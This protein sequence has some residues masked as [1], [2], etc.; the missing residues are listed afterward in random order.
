MRNKLEIVL[1]LILI[2]GIGI[3]YLVLPQREFSEMENRYLSECPEFTW[4]EL[5]NGTYTEK[6]EDYTA[7]QIVG[8][9]LLVKLNVAVNRAMGVTEIQQV[10]IGKD[11]YLIQDYQEPGE[12]LQENLDYIRLFAMEHPEI[13]M[14]MLLVP[15]ASEIYPEELPAFAETYSQQAVIEEA[16]KALEPQIEVVDATDSLLTHKEEELYFKTDHHWN[17]LG[18]YYAYVELCKALEVEPTPYSQYQAEVVEQPFYGSL[19]SKAPMFGQVP[20]EMILLKNPEGQY[21]V[22][23]V[24]ENRET[25]SMLDYSYAEKKDKYAIYFG[26]NYPLTVIRSQG[27]EQEKVLII[28][29]SYA[30]SLVPML[31]DQYGEIHMMDLRYYHD[32]V[33]AYIEE[34]GITRVIFIHNV[35][36]IS[37]DNNF[38][39]L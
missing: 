26:G 27:E 35:D 3:G 16:V 37:T 17:A 22:N 28:K 15:N 32:D 13:T 8:K 33:D 29:D 5:L 12:L 14:T 4:K 23:Y 31:A 25:D 2:F 7:D 36:F 6:F 20:D 1:F 39:W 9:D 38:L 11:G 19:Y 24:N 18:T 10:Y 30:N 21:Q 34:Q